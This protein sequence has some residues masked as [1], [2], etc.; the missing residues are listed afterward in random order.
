MKKITL[1]VAALLVL[2]VSAK[3]AVDFKFFDNPHFPVA[4]NDDEPISFIERG[5]AFYIFP[6]GQFD[7]NTEPSRGDI[8][9]KN[10]RRNANSNQTFGAPTNN[11]G[12]GIRIEHDNL[13][14]IRRVGNVFINYDFNDRIKRIG[15]VYMIYNRFALAQVGGLHIIYNRF[16]QV[17]NFVGSVKDRYGYYFYN[18]NDNCNSNGYGQSNGHFSNTL[19]NNNNNNDDPGQQNEDN[20]YYKKNKEKLEEDNKTPENESKIRNGRR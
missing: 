3:A 14:R 1:L 16:G 4:I 12:G 13:G 20:Y 17:V 10:G 11:F 5:I 8:Y 15:S 18:E 19:G 7:F 9:Y 2:S 6:D